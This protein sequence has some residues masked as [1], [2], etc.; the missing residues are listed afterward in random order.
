MKPLEGIR[1][2]DL[3]RILAG[4][5][6]SMLLADM[7]AEV[8]KIEP[9]PTGDEARNVGPFLDSMSAYFISLN[10]GKKSVAVNLKDPRGR[11]VL[12][13][14]VRK[15]DIL[16]E[17]FRPGTMKRLGLDFQTLREVN[18]RLIYASCSG[19]GQTG[20]YAH[21]GAYDMII[22]GMGGIISITGEPGRP[23]VRVGTS[24]ADLG[25]G[26]FTTIGILAALQARERTGQGQHVDVSMLDALVA[27]LENA[28]IRYTVTGEVPGPLG[29]RHPS[30]TPFEVFPAKDGS[31]V[32]AVGTKLWE[33]FCQALGRS[34]LLEDPRFTTNALRTEH[35]AEL[36]PLIAEVTR[37]KTAAEWIRIMEEAGVPCGPI[38]TVDKVV[39]DPQIKARGMIV[40]IDQGEVGKVRIAGFPI[41]FS[42]TPGGV[43]GRAP[44]LGE[45]TEE[46][47]TGLLGYSK[48]RIEELRRDGVV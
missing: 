44:R 19:F 21:R 23:P 39:E 12:L 1:V 10:R 43:Q 41:K 24:I 28:I 16:L 2:V 11:A 31:V 35:Q 36:F 26:L 29:A 42:M 38:N 17:N 34:E 30:I 32:I 9:L 18:P 40:E 5:Y 45:H 14:L 3:S 7:G 27:L 15:A 25:G 48:E 6:C 46:V 20:P 47:L 4:P 37:T 22:Q 13:D 33:P 8:I